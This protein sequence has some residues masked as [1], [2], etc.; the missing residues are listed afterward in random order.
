MTANTKQEKMFQKSWK[1]FQNTWQI[2]NKY[3][4]EA[5]SNLG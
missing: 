2:L 1:T 3:L 4:N 5:L